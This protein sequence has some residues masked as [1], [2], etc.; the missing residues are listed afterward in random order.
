VVLS[1]PPGPLWATDGM[2]LS[3]QHNLHRNTGDVIVGRETALGVQSR[4]E[5]SQVSAMYRN[6]NDNYNVY[7]VVEPVDCGGGF[8]AH[9]QTASLAPIHSSL[10]NGGLEYDCFD[11]GTRC[12][13]HY[14][15]PFPQ[16]TGNHVLS[17]HD[18]Y[19]TRHEY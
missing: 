12:P 17:L 15:L 14:G 13:P 11:N 5:D 4:W 16:N 6:D 9:A 7:S 10:Y 2:K 1:V 8:V 19:R 3:Q 18:Q